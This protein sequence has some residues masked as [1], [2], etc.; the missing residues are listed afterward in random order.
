MT[1]SFRVHGIPAPQAGSRAVPTKQG[2]RLITTGGTNLKAWRNDVSASAQAA[3]LLY[4]TL[5]GPLAITVV[6]RF[7]MPKS[8]PKKLREIGSWWKVT[9]PDTDKLLRSL[10]DSLKAGGLIADDALIASWHAT[11]VEVWEQ[12]T[13]AEIRI[14]EVTS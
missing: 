3:A 8:R 6:F 7:P 9:A 13:G 12:W 5:R 1:I 10:G 4:G 2:A 11:K 14:D